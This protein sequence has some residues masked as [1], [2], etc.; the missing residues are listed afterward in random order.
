[1]NK[2][3]QQLGRLGGKATSEAKRRANREK[4]KAYWADVRAGRRDAPKHTKRRMPNETS[5]ATGGAT[6]KR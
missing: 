6:I 4:I 2:A 1:M 3:A 5:S